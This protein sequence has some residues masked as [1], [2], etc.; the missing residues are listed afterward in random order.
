MFKFLSFAVLR[1]KYAVHAN[2]TCVCS[3]LGPNLERIACENIYS[4]Q[5]SLLINKNKL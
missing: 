5:K 2:V 1:K 3:F 4:V